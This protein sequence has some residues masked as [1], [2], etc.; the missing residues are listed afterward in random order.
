[1]LE[2]NGTL[3]VLLVS[4]LLFMWA[5]NLVFVKPVAAVLAARASNIEG[6]LNAARDM[7]KQAEEKTDSYQ[8]GLGSVREQAQAIINTA[9]GEAQEKRNKEM[10]KVMEEGRQKL[11]AA[12]RTLAEEKTKLMDGLVEEEV[13]LVNMMLEKLLGPGHASSLS[14]DQGL[15]RKTLEE[16]L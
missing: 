2:L 8:K 15:V 7:R 10:E 11:E 16:A 4:F 14:Q 3:I 1:M 9:I 5:L 12:S 13:K 6:D